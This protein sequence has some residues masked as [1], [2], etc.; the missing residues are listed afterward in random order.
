M[1]NYGFRP[2]LEDPK[3][4]VLG[5]INSLPRV[6]RN[7]SGNWYEYLPLFEKQYGA[8][9]TYGCTVFG[10]L[11]A[12]ETLIKKVTGK[13]Y[14]FAERYN[15]NLIKLEPPGADPKEAA[16]SIR[17]NGVVEQD[18]L[19]FPDTFDEF[20]SPR[21]IT[22]ELKNEG[23]HWLEKFN[24]GYE[25]I[26]KNETDSSKRLAI[27]KQTL[28]FSPIGISVT[29][30]FQND[31]GEFYSPLGESNNHWCVLFKLD[32][33]NRPVIFDTYDQSVK[34]LSADHDIRFAMRYHIDTLE[35][36]KE[37]VSIIQKMVVL[38]NDLLNLFKKK[39]SAP[40]INPVINPVIN[41]PQMSNQEKVLQTAQ[42]CLDIDVSKKY[43]GK[44]SVPN[45]VACA[46]S[47]CLILQQVLDFPLLPLTSDLHNKLKSDPRFE[48][49]YFP[50]R[51]CVIVS[52]NKGDK[53]GHAGIFIT[54][55][56]I[57]SNDS[58]TGKFKGNF[59]WPENWLAVFGPEGRGLHTYIYK[60]KE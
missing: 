39:V 47:V 5:G 37:K 11:N 49:T 53:N 60:L 42:D 7:P 13:E 8:F 18:L 29:A 34:T 1:K 12:F 4:K 9:E 43:L 55:T 45:E 36:V 31:K 6:V 22:E 24:F 38:L 59:T 10:S 30:W 20:R 40:I 16:Q 56:R 28:P 25:W 27:I 58:K 54:D 19:P 46:E 51:G 26:F 57:A 21:P 44:D 32:E 23:Y 15:Y 33:Q 41:P 52:P 3:D 35:E 14:N 50:S 48:A 2:P 17:S